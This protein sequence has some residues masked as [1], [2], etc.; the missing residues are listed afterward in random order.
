M[1][2][3]AIQQVSKANCS[4]VSLVPLNEAIPLFLAL[5]LLNEGGL[6]R[7][8]EPFACKIKEVFNQ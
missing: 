5:C 4:I 1:G 7:I 3:Q 6:Y 2:E 8:V